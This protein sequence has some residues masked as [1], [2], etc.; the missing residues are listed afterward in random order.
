MTAQVSSLAS[1]GLDNEFSNTNWLHSPR[2]PQESPGTLRQRNTKIVCTVG[3]ASANRDSIRQLIRAGANVFRLNFSHGDHAWHSQALRLIRDLAAEE[4]APVAIM[5]DLCGPK[6]RIS[7]MTQSPFAVHLDDLVRITTEEHIALAARGGY[8]LDYDLASNYPSL[9]CD[10][11]VGD[12]V[13]IDD[14]RIELVVREKQPGILVTQSR[15]TGVILDG[16]GINLP[17]VHLSTDSV[18]AKD[19]E[20]LEW[21]I[22][23]EVDFVALS[24]VRHPHDLVPVHSR[25]DEVGSHIRLIAKIERPEAIEHLEGILALSDGLM[26]ARGDLGVETDLA[27]VPCLQKSLIERSRQAGKPVIT[28]TQMLESMVHAATPT[29]AEVSDVANAIFDGSDAIMLSAETATGAYPE[30]AVNVLHR[31]ALVA[32]Q[33]LALRHESH[34]RANTTSGVAAA[35]VEGAATTAL[36][37]KAKQ[38]VVYSQSGLTARLLARC[39]LPMPVVAVTNIESTFRQLSLS[40]GVRPLYLPH[41]V[42]LPQLLREMDE[43]ALAQAWGEVGDALVVVS[44]LDGRDGNTDTLHVH[45]IR[46]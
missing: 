33:D 41:I 44:A 22:L 26:V 39:R 2:R 30:Q 20:D 6:I 18:T 16:K 42:D 27:R 45:L 12:S 28:A 11:S 21:G 7:R 29:R 14:G 15:T 40:F 3:P 8:S 31:V 36:R 13:L 19:W 34:R 24:F 23:H 9:W 46:N 43:L 37:L 25:L 17:G 5:Q 32:E 38:L 10:L 1:F 35:I 4:N